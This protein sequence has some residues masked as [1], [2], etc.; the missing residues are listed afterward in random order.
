MEKFVVHSNSHQPRYR[1]DPVR[2]L[3][4]ILG[5]VIIASLTFAPA[6]AQ[7]YET[8]NAIKEEVAKNKA[9][10]D[11]VC[12]KQSDPLQCQKDFDTVSTMISGLQYAGLMYR[13][14]DFKVAKHLIERVLDNIDDAKKQLNEKYK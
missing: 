10:R 8:T 9:K 12:V 2:K 5:F 7:T 1:E 6:N 13:S 4:T 11:Q 3:F 14:L